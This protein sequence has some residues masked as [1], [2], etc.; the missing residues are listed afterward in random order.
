MEA[1][2]SIFE[3]LQLLINTLFKDKHELNPLR[4]SKKIELSWNPQRN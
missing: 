1:I 2:G 4:S 3:I